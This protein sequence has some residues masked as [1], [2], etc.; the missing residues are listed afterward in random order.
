MVTRIL[1]INKN[2]NWN[3]FPTSRILVCYIKFMYTVIQKSEK[4]HD[5]IYIN[6]PPDY[7]PYAFNPLRGS[8]V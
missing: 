1:K 6:L 3:K 5:M 2:K 8:D 7:L 4:L